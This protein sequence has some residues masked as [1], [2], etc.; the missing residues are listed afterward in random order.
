[1]RWVSVILGVVLGCAIGY[2]LAGGEPLVAPIV[3]VIGVAAI[4]ATNFIQKSKARR[5]GIVLYDEMHLT[6]AARSG[7]TALRASILAV[8]LITFITAWPRFFNI[9][10]LPAEVADMLFPG[11]GL[12]LAIMTIAYLAAYIYYLK[13]KKVL[14]G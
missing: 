12:S 8:G 11:L 6:V 2:V 14:E 9:N 1:M 5:Q 10:I 13:S 7:Y 4:L 3:A